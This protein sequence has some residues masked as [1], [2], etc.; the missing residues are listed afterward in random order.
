MVPTGPSANLSEKIP[1]RNS[2]GEGFT[3]ITEQTTGHG[4]S[5]M[6]MNLRI[7]LHFSQ[8]SQ[9]SYS[10]MQS[11]PKY[12]NIFQGWRCRRRDIDG[13]TQA[14]FHWKTSPNP[15]ATGSSLAFPTSQSSM[16]PHH[17]AVESLLPRL[18]HCSA[19]LVHRI[20]ES[21]TATS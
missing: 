3:P 15:R 19:W 8:S 6:P 2:I 9:K 12:S 20:C 14:D 17:Q 1:C 4:W 10:P 5:S 21:T 16:I 11:P 18:T 13:S 7:P